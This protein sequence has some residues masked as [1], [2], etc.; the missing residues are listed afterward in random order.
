MTNHVHLVV[1]D[2]FLPGAAAA[3]A[4]AGLRTPGLGKILA[5]ARAAPLPV[6]SLQDWLCAAFGVENQNVAPIPLQGDGVDAGTAYWLR[7]DPVHLMLR[8]NELLV[9]PVT[10]LDPEEAGTLCDSLNRH[11]AEDGLHFVAPVP[12]RWYLRLERAPDISMRPVAQVVGGDMHAHLP[13]GREALQWHRLL[14]EIQMLLSDHAVNQAREARG[15]WLINSIWLWGGGHAPDRLARPFDRVYADNA[16]AAAFATVAGITV[17]PLP[18]DAAQCL[19]SGTGEMLMV[20][21][22]PGHAWQHGDIGAWRDSVEHFDRHYAAPLLQALR[23][24]RIDG[25][26]L[27]VL[28]AQGSRRFVLTRAMAWQFWRLSRPLASF[29][30]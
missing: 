2:L 5:R 15:D 16:L 4:Y 9:R 13:Q 11:F 21:D 14:N 28:L 1:P 22:G 18:D 19:A 7:A 10:A 27:D 25:I 26:T 24:G 3:E 17:A 8:G 6:A 20:W 29:A 23:G 12:Q 30:G